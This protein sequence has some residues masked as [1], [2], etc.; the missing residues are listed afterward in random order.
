MKKG[1]LSQYFDRAAAKCLKAAETDSFISHQHEF[2]SANDL[3]I[4]FGEPAGKTVYPA[5][6]IRPLALHK[7]K[8]REKFHVIDSSDQTETK[9]KTLSPVSITLA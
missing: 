3:K 7:S 8:S 1:Y 4:I 2:N 6:F 5:R 9:S